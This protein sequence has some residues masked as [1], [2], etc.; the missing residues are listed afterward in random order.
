VAEFQEVL[1]MRL[2]PLVFC[3]AVVLA[4]A[5][6]GFAQQP[7]GP[8]TLEGL[9]NTDTAQKPTAAADAD[10]TEAGPKRPAGTVSRPKDGV[11]HPDLD[12]AWAGYDAVIAKVNDSIKAAIAEQFDAATAKGDLDA[13][14]KWQ[15][16]LE[17][18]EK[19]GEVPVEPETK[20]TVSTA[21]TE[22][23]QAKEELGKSYDAVVTVLTKEKNI[24]EAKAVRDEK[25]SQFVS[26]H[27][28]PTQAAIVL[29]ARS[30]KRA[31]PNVADREADRWDGLAVPAEASIEWE[32]IVP[33]LGEYYLHVHYASGEERPC[34]IRL[35]GKEVARNALG[36]RT[37]GFMRSNLQWQTIGPLRFNKSNV[38][39]ID[40]DRHGPHFDRF[41]ISK[42][43]DR[44][45]KPG[46]SLPRQKLLAVFVGKWR[47]ADNGNV[48][49]I[50]A[51]GLF[52][53]NKNPSNEWSGRWFLDLKDPR[54]A[55]VVREAN[56]RTST[57]WYIDLENPS[58][59][60]AGDGVRLRKQE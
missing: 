51:N 44:P 9:L 22:Y 57:R 53:V 4:C 41:V 5:A 50:R 20:A 17:R 30:Y 2:W 18:F 34:V 15:A 23:K 39:E 13:A 7:T 25:A 21:V 3:F 46:E 35:N 10:A 60:V 31:T 26:S 11:Q 36:G 8:A 42:T 48:E 47:N 52:V 12:K 55:C 40:P 33:E 54:G 58:T 37:G 28:L 1:S 6:Q 38:L 59:L 19:A 16:A 29:E 24:S 45:D 43:A 27:V 56:N 32:A 14:E 49:E